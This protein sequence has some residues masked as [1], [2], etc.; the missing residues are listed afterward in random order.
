MSNFFTSPVGRP[1]GPIP[2]RPIKIQNPGIMGLP[3]AQP[4]PGASPGIP[5]GDKASC[6]V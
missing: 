2:T 6:P 4:A 3:Q 5:T 1:T